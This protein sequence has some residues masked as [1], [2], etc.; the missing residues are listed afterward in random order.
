MATAASSLQAGSGNERFNAEALNWDKNPLVHE[1]SKQALKAISARF[2]TLKPSSGSTGLDVLEIGCGT[3]LLSTIVAPLVKQVVAIDAAPGMIDVL[4]Q[5]LNKEDAPRNIVPVAVLL[6]DPEDKSLPPADTANPDGPRLKFDLITSH[7]V[8]HHVPDLKGL[9]ATMLG[10]LKDGASVALTDFE[11]DGPDAKS[12]HPRSKMDG[13][14]R[15]GIHAETMA[16]LMKDVGLVNVRVER[17]W[18][19]DKTVEKFEGE[20]G[21]ATPQPGMG[22]I[23]SFPFVICM[24]ERKA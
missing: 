14:E 10:C 12:F 5:K 19:M 2:P 22:K 4:K 20:F 16:A 17:A 11:D 24:G 6:E 21:K 18:S 1:A 9:L 13:V 3:G 8:L 7:L 23:R 15:H